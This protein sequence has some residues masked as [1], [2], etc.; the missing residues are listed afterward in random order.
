MW[1]NSKVQ[2]LWGISR[3]TGESN[4]DMHEAITLG[5]AVEKVGI[6]GPA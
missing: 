4:W 2:I 1:S 5:W 6:I 3:Q